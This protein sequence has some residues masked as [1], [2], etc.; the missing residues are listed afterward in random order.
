MLKASIPVKF[1]EYWAQNAPGG[2]VTYPVPV[3]TGTPGRASL[4]QGWP[5]ITLTPLNAGALPA[6]GRDDN[7][8]K[9][10]ISAWLQWYQAGAQ[11]PWDSSFSTAVGGYPLGAIVAHAT[12]NGFFWLHGTDA[13]TTHPDAR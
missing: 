1:N 13:N 10:Q 8:M 3:T 12:V 9:R 7:G 6:D 4:D 11:V 5:T 2:N